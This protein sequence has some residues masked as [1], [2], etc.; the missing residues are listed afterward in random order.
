MADELLEE[1]KRTNAE[2]DQEVYELYG[3][4]PEEREI[5]ETFLAGKRPRQGE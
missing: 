3:L 2:I 4:T 1:I 5:I